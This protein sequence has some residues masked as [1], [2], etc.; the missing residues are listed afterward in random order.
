MST[1]VKKMTLSSPLPFGP[2]PSLP[3][4][5]ANSVHGLNAGGGTQRLNGNSTLRHLPLQKP[6]WY[7]QERRFG[8]DVV[9]FSVHSLVS[10]NGMKRDEEKKKEVMRNSTGK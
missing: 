3:F 4:V 8:M 6:V 1:R 5:S 9:F 10:A 2:S 7:I